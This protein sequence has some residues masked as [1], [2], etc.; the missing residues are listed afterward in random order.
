[1][2]IFFC[3]DRRSVLL[4]RGD[5]TEPVD[6]TKEASRAVFAL[7]VRDFHKREAGIRDMVG[8]PTA[9]C[10]EITYLETEDGDLVLSLGRPEEDED[11]DIELFY[12]APN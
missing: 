11:E 5:G 12:S 6:I 8:D 7:L 1:M 2:E 9:T 3:K 4:D 10:T